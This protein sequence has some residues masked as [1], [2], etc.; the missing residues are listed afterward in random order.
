MARGATV[1]SAATEASVDWFSRLGAPLADDEAALAAGYLAALDLPAHTRIEVARDWREAERLIRNPLTETGWWARE[2]SERRLLMS[3][4]ATR[5]GES[6][7]FETLTAA[8]EGYA[9]ATY[10]GALAAGG[11]DEAAAK[12][13]SGAALMT[14][15]CKALALLAGRGENHLFVQKYALFARGR[16]PLGMRATDS[17]TL[18]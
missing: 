16:W 12:V 15:H 18:F 7:L 6:L 13:A 1:I 9:E 14:V 4:A 11:G 3:E 10:S 17:F 2:E 8:V 5:I